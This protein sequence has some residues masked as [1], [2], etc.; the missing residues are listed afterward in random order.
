MR[1]PVET[2][3]KKKIEIIIEAPALQKV[4]R[5]FETRKII[6]YTIFAV[7][8]GS[9]H[10][11]RWDASGLVGDSGRMLSVVCVLDQKELDIV[12][13]YIEPIIRTQIGIVLVSDVQVIRR[14]HF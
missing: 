10:E 2:F 3:A 9:G 4:L 12:L 8:A 14:N 1:A 7:L 11:G 5:V 13:G 6:G